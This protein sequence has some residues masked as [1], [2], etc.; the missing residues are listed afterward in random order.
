MGLVSSGCGAS[1]EEILDKLYHHQAELSHDLGYAAELLPIAYETTLRDF[2]PDATAKECQ[3]AR[4]IALGVYAGTAA[5][6]P[7]IE[8]SLA[9]LARHYDLY[10]ITAGDDEVQ[11]KRVKELP[12]K[13]L[14]KDVF[15]VADK[16]CATYKA[17]LQ[18]AGHTADEAI[19]I[20]DSLRSDIHPAIEAGMTAIYVP[21]ENWIARET[22][23]HTLPAS[24]RVETYALFSEAAAALLARKTPPQP[25]QKNSPPAG[26]RR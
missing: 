1:R 18:K 16:N 10:I 15:I 12:F 8:N 9:K 22:K 7:G 25:G 13:N 26:P 17:V 5:I 19:M 20:G 4:S 2:V 21:G 11:Q 14:F 24:E 3:D 23:G 6:K